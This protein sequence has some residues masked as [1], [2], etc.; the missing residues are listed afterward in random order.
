MSRF[1]I[2]K[3]LLRREEI[4]KQTLVVGTTQTRSDMICRLIFGEIHCVQVWEIIKYSHGNTFLIDLVTCTLCIEMKISVHM[5]EMGILICQNGNYLVNL[6]P[7]QR[8][9]QERKDCT[10]SIT[11]TQR[12]L[13]TRVPR[14]NRNKLVEDMNTSYRKPSSTSVKAETRPYKHKQSDAWERFYNQT[15]ADKPYHRCRRN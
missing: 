5:S 15:A 6:T 14:G 13:E 4:A 7:D 10:A 11:G 2:I 3:F 8:S 12:H 1:L 9:L